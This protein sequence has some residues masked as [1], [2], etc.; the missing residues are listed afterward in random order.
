MATQNPIVYWSSNSS[1][2]Q[3]LLACSKHL[4]MLCSTPCTKNIPWGLPLVSIKRSGKYPLLPPQRKERGALLHVISNRTMQT[5]DRCHVEVAFQDQIILGNYRLNKVWE[6]YHSIS[7]IYQICS[8]ALWIFKKTRLAK[9][10]KF[11]WLQEFY[12]TNFETHWL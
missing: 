12:K 7:Q 6:A 1:H 9:F 3:F 10:S 5:L 4:A 11:T 2:P 8:N